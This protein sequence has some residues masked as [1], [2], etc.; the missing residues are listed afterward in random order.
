MADI[1][2]KING[3]SQPFL[4]Q[5]WNGDC[6]SL[7]QQKPVEYSGTCVIFGGLNGNTTYKL[8]IIDN[9]SSSITSTFNTPS[10]LIAPVLTTKY[11]SLLGTLTTIDQYN[12]QITSPKYVCV[13]PPLSNG[14]SVDLNFNIQTV[15][16]SNT[17]NTIDLFCNG[18]LLSSS[19]INSGINTKLINMKYGDS[20]CYNMSSIC[21]SSGNICGHSILELTGV[22]GY[23]FS[24][25]TDS[26]YCKSTALS[27]P[28]TT[29]TTTTTLTPVSIFLCNIT[30]LSTFPTSKIC[31]CSKLGSSRPLVNGEWFRLYHTSCARS[32]TYTTHTEEIK[33]C[34]STYPPTDF[35]LASSN[36]SSGILD[37]CTSS[38][39]NYIDICS[40]N[41]NNITFWAVADKISSSNSSSHINDSY[42]CLNNITC[43]TGA[44]F[45]LDGT[46]KL[47]ACI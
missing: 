41:I 44:N 32:I 2:F 34:A 42:V 40:T 47:S 21:S 30:Q 28:T 43:K 23:G 24:A 3:S 1:S 6:S 39:Y 27:I 4:A 15:N 33:A 14:E 36:V 13:N 16:S 10:E 26:N 11:V 45:I 18:N 17:I 8:N 29:T 9:I 5:L 31:Y 38:N 20:I 7:I 22:T 25:C 46:T 35:N 37:G 19:Y 12:K